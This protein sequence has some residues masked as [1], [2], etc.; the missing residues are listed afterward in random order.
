[1]IRALA[2]R[3]VRAAIS[4]LSIDEHTVGRAEK[5]IMKGQSC[6]ASEGIE[7]KD[8]RPVDTTKAGTEGID[9]SVRRAHLEE[10]EEAG[11]ALWIEGV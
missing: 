11:V 5:G 10:E 4:A 2:A 6:P 1:M 7:N 8:P 3:W 9:E